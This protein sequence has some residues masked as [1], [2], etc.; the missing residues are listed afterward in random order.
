MITLWFE[1]FFGVALGDAILTMS[2][3][4]T[5]ILIAVAVAQIIKK[6]IS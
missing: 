6:T 1:T 5:Y 4:T 2:A 3:I